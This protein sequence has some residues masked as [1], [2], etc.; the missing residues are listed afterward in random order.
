MAKKEKFGKFVL[1]EEV[2]ATGLGSEFRAAKLSATGLEKIVTVVRLN[3]LLA[4]HADAAKNLMEHVKFAAQL[5]NPNILKIYGIGKVDQ[6]Y[7]ISYEFLEGK[8]LKAI[9]HR[10]RQEG[11][12]FS[13]DHALLIASKVCSALEYA[14]GRKTESGGRYFHGLLDPANVLVSYE[15]EV[16]TRGFG[17]WPSKVRDVGVR[18][19]DEQ[20]YL[21]PEQA[22]GAGDHR[23]DIFA[24]GALLFE[25]LTGQPLFQ[26]GR[27]DDVAGRIAQARLQ[28][29]TTDDDSVPRPIA[30]ILQRSLAVDPA[31]RYGEMQEMRKG[32]D[33]LLFSG[34][35]TPTTFNLAFFM[36]S[37]FREDIDRESKALKDDKDS[38]YLD[39]LE[40]KAA[41]PAPVPAPVAA[42]PVVPA[43]SP[44]AP[45][46][47]APPAPR[48]APAAAA[49]VHKPEPA[50]EPHPAP[51]PPPRREPVVEAPDTFTFHKEEPSGSKL[52]LLIGAAAVLIIGGALGFFMLRG[53]GGPPTPTTTTPTVT[54]LS[55][56]E[57][58]LAALKAKMAEMEAA[59]K[60][61]EDAAAAKVREKAEAAARARGEQ[62][63]A[64][65]L[66]AAEEEARRKA[67]AEA[68]RK[69]LE[70]K[71]RLEAEALA[72]QA[73]MEDEKKRAAEAAAAAAA[74]ATPTP[75]PTTAAAATPP[76]AAATRPGAL[77]NIDEPGVVP[78]VR[79]RVPALQYP[80][81]CRTQK[82]EGS[83][84]LSVLVDEKGNVN[85]AKIV[86]GAGGKCGMNEAAQD[87]V[88]R[89][90]FR[91]AMKDGVNVKV[92]T[93]VRVTFALPK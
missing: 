89:W 82:I 76:P 62:V 88:K 59:K 22:S 87:F 45:P 77:V 53:K 73:R 56:A 42:A 78:P 12:P 79:D 7:Y 15:G 2:E 13:V 54:T 26:G 3:P 84:E 9:F 75:P 28:S 29:P 31:A 51:A 14:H 65:K 70:E 40:D 86:T 37:L 33:T 50:P 57:Q 10:C 74:A 23:S 30:E 38:S 18:A 66:A 60:A 83:V 67:A 5:Q 58:E 93:P 8:S 19:E 68:E 80:P 72:A 44:V 49:P 48:P 11:F 47:A 20:L 4:S 91:P 34:D 55:A 92:W 71:R 69:Q 25:T 41:A 85:D 16:R 21:A 64:A 1:L 6:T 90:K 52:P 17:F 36:H 63:D 27:T 32:I 61:E 43:P 35:F 46:V 81:I 39:F 24:V